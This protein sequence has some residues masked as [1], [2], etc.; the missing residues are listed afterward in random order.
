LKKEN[1]LIAAKDFERIAQKLD[2]IEDLRAY[3]A[4]LFHASLH[5][6]AYICEL[7]LG[8]HRNTHAGLSKFLREHNLDELANVFDDI[9]RIRIGCVYGGKIGREITSTLRSLFKEIKEWV[10][11]CEKKTKQF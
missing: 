11:K 9:S 8:K 6:I 2:P 1:H 7:S 3:S 4:L 5:Y 10:K